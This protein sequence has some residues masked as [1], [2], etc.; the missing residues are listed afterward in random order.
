[1]PG[2]DG[3]MLVRQYR[4]HPVTRDVPVI[5]LSSKEE[6]AVKSEAFAAGANDYLVK[7][8]DNL[9]LIARIRYHSKAYGISSSV[10]KP[11]GPCA[12]ASSNSLR[13]T[14]PSSRSTRSSRKPPTPSRSFWPT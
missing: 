4:A 13:P 1:M 7:L 11:T 5:V 10:T 2:A 14:L 6:P 12:R 3:L 9:E 8:P